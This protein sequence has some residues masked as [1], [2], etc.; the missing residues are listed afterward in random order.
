MDNS[1]FKPSQGTKKKEQILDDG[2]VLFWLNVVIFG[3]LFFT[4]F[5]IL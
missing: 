3:I 5:F 2:V 1:V 4:Y